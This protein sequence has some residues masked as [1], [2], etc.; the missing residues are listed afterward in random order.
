M[1]IKAVL[2]DFDGTLTEPGSLD[3]A[4]IRLAIGCP[5]SQPI[6]EFI[7][8]LPSEKERREAL[9]TLD[10]SERRAAEKS[11]PNRGA[12][13]L[14]R[15]IRSRNLKLGIISRNSLQ[16]I[17]CALDNFKETRASDFTVILSRDDPLI[18]KPSPEGIRA[19]AERMG[20]PV[21]NL[22][23]V[24]DFIFDIRAGR[25][26]G[27]TTVYLSNRNS[28][29]ATRQL[30]DFTIDELGEL[31]QIVRLNVALPEG[32]LPNDL[33]ADFLDELGWNKADVLIAP[34]IG[35]DAAAIALDGEEVLILKSDPITFATDSIGYYSV[36]VNAN[37]I[38]TS[39]AS[40]RWLLATLLFPPG[41]TAEQVH[42]VMRELQQAAFGHGMRVCGGHT[43]IT[44]A[45]RRPVIVSQAVGTV[46]R[47][48][49]LDKKN[50]KRG[51]QVLITKGIAIEGTS[52]LA[53]EFPALLRKRAAGEDL[54][55]RC[56]KFLHEPGISIVTEARR[57]AGT[58]AVSAM[59]DATE[60]GLATALEELSAAGGHRIRI[61]RDR[62]PVLAETREVC[63]LLEIDPLGLIAS[64]SL[65][66]TCA[67]DRAGEVIHSIRDAGINVVCIGEVL[68]RG[69]GLEALSDENG[70]PVAWP[71]FEADEIA[72]VFRQYGHEQRPRW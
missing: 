18:P 24:G 66:L 52:I 32:K 55:E 40:P 35:E 61:F 30:A 44:G 15:F 45:V 3:F 16:S 25:S 38:A 33:L 65:L 54:L 19:A 17:L 31:R 68:E 70:V 69:S 72:R 56:R 21:E 1:V 48:Q 13:E 2:F 46:P 63:G 20:V 51:D 43:E 26:A 10:E 5:L 7:E 9:R 29:P 36:V 67:K 37:D 64:G 39:G 47:S 8:S 71:H 34:G 14:L 58:G 59:H 57:A 28:D 62:I 53:R 49:L 27:A 50:I 6:L 22:L 23:V 60:G 11:Q 4:A 12:E 42:Q 41:T